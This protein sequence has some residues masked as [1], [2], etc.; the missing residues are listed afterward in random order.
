VPT[1]GS[2]LNY[3]HFVHTVQT[4]RLQSINKIVSIESDVIFLPEKL[5]TFGGIGHGRIFKSFA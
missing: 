4:G 3:S 5:Q 1:T 2:I